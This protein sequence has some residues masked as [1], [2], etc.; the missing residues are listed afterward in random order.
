MKYFS[1]MDFSTLST[2][3]HIVFLNSQCCLFNMS[4]YLCPNFFWVCIY[5]SRPVLNV[6]YEN[7]I[8]CL[9]IYVGGGKIF[10]LFFNA[11]CQKS[12]ANSD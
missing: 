7:I 6:F 3:L 5:S 1:K 12:P 4:L 11:Y 9:E 2:T 8:N 10:T